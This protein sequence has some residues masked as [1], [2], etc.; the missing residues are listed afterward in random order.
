MA[1]ETERNGGTLVAMTGERVDGMNAR[2]LQTDLEEAILESDRAVVLDL[3]R[4]VYISSAG[5]RVILLTAKGL[6]R[7]Q[8]KLAVCSLSDLVR[9]IF[10]I[11]GF[12]KIIPVHETVPDALIALKG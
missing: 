10:E 2:E 8:A 1:I 3:Q 4:L 11:S 6:Q 5:L 9:E 12:D 7:R